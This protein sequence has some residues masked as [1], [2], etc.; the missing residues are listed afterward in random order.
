MVLGW[1][2]FA[3][4]NLAVQKIVFRLILGGIIT[5][6]VV[7]SF[8][9][10]GIVLTIWRS[11]TVPG[12]RN[13]MRVAISSLFPIAIQLG[14]L[15]GINKEKIRSSYIEVNNQLVS[16]EKVVLDP[17]EILI[18][19][20][21]CLQMHDC[22]Y[23]ITADI[24]NCHRCGRCSVDKLLQLADEY[25]VN[26]VIATGGTLARKFI[27][28]YKPRAVV[29]VACERDL[30]SGIQDSNPLPV[31]GVLNLRPNGPCYDT[32]VNL[33]RVK[34]AI[35]YFLGKQRRLIKSKQEGA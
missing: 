4:Q 5:F 13:V 16:T 12:L 32:S 24:N 35:E 11:R 14:Q 8:G 10:A 18:L 22:P 6:L 3:N 23:K 26:V 27:T 1:Y 29:A 31:L 21:H 25:R 9:I 19:A 2:I 7:V 28:E 20:P 15:M 30:T 33:E 17:G 34:G